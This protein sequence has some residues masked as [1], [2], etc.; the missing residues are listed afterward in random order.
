[1]SYIGK[2]DRGRRRIQARTAVKDTAPSFT[3]SA[4][5]KNNDRGIKKALISNT[6]QGFLRWKGQNIEPSSDMV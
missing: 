2:I 4:L 1:L 5:L 6:N 3:Q